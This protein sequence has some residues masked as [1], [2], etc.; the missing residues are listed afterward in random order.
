MYATIK[1]SNIRIC[2]EFLEGIK[3][4]LSPQ[5][6]DLRTVTA[7]SKKYFEES[8]G[9]EN[10]KFKQLKTFIHKL[11]LNPSFLVLLYH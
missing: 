10:I 11:Y 7:T 4:H 3:A 9:S 8:F 5:E 2:Q 1:S 6:Q